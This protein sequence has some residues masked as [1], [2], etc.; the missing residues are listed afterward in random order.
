MAFKKATKTQVKLRMAI[1]GPSGSG[2]TFTALTVADALAD[3]QGVAVIDTE[4]GSAAK[5]ADMFTF[6]VNE[7]D[8][9][10]PDAFI[11]A[12]REA[13][14]ENYAVLVIDS[15]SHEWNG[16]GGILEIVDHAT[17]R[18][19]TPNSYVAWGEGTPRHN[20]FVEAILRS[21]MHII[22]TMRSKE[23]YVQER[24]DNGRTVIRK[25]GM[26]PI[27]R[28]GI[29]YEFDVVAELD[30][31]HT[32]VVTKSRCHTFSDA[33]IRKPD[34]SSFTPLKSW[35]DDGEPA[36][37]VEY[38]HPSDVDALTAKWAEAYHI[39]DEQVEARWPKYKVHV[40]GLLIPDEQ[41]QASHVAT[42]K[43]V[44]EDYNRKAAQPVG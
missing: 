42:L 22:C 29:Q 13:E 33:V 1:A 24:G 27:Q 14:Q 7:L 31:E 11:A 15:I 26:A 39:P 40:L 30:Y 41:L 9:F 18:M 8:S 32:L 10:S 6:D 21:K 16:A 36:P 34:A 44:I 17:K 37:I 19:K 12:I 23:D 35:L 2:K 4:R 28:D 20:A 5:Y 3:G 25:M 38:V 43:K